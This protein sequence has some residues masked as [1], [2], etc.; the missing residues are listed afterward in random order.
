[1]LRSGNYLVPMLN[2]ER[3]HFS[4]PPL[5]Y[6]AIAAGIRL[7]GWNEWGARLANAVAFALTVLLV[8]FLGTRLLADRPWLP[9]LVYSTLALPYLAANVLSTDTLLTAWETL[10]MAGFVGWWRGSDPTAGRWWRLLMWT[11]FGFA[12]LTKGPPALLP[13]LG[14]LVFLLLIGQRTRLGRLLYPPGVLLFLL[15]GLTWFVVVVSMRPQLLGFFLGR[16]V[17]ERIATGVHRRNAEWY[18][19]L[20]AYLPTLL[21]GALPW[22]LLLLRR[23]STVRRI[24]RRRW[25]STTAREHPEHLLAL[26]WFLVPLS[27]FVVVRS[28]LPLYILPLFVPLALIIARAIR[29]TFSLSRRTEALLLLWFGILV[30]AR[31]A[32]ATLRSPHDARSLAAAIVAAVGDCPREVVFVDVQAAWGLSLYLDTQIKAVSFEPGR[33]WADT[34]VNDE[35]GHATPNALF[36]VPE[37]ARG[38]LA[39]ALKARSLAARWSGGSDNVVFLHISPAGS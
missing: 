1:M 13:L 17:V 27:V 35:L 15:I 12:F 8:W 32:A 33:L 3:P 28:R 11:G 29:S 19:G 14:V 9:P 26:L 16:E 39:R 24:F 37:R 18:G 7:L 34:T 36:V 2:N 6:W 23:L 25:W 5:T 38:R 20:V 31:G 4:K 21:I 10:A 30:A 22:S